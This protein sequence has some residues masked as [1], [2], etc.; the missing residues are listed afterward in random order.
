MFA[1]FHFNQKKTF[2]T[3]EKEH[4]FCLDKVALHWVELR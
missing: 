4:Y 1:I 2:G 3:C